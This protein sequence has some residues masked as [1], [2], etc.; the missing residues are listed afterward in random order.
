MQFTFEPL[1]IAQEYYY[2]AG[3]NSS[4]TAWFSFENMPSGQGAYWNIGSSTLK[5]AA[6]LVANTKY[7]CDIIY[8]NGSLSATIGSYTYTTSY[9]GSLGTEYLRF[10]GS[11]TSFAYMKLYSLK[12]Y[13]N[14]TTLAHDLIPAKVDSTGNI[15][16]YDRVTRKFY[17]NAGS[18]AFVAG[19]ET[20][21]IIYDVA[22]YTLP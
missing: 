20:G 3:N 4:G 10:F 11:D 19:A 18:G 13:S 2:Y 15:G 6:Q 7:E 22:P 21:G 9:S 12:L 14:Q 8:N 1:S 16:F 5:G 17:Y